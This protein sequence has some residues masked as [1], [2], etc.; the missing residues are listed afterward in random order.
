[1]RGC[2]MGETSSPSSRLGTF[3]LGAPRY[4]CV[5]EGVNDLYWMGLETPVAW[6][7]PWEQLPEGAPYDRRSFCVY[8]N[9]MM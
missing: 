3:N 9:L 4:V 6:H 2:P 5:Q 7:Q 1:M 8:R